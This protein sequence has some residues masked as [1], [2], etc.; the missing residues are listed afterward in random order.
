MTSLVRKCFSLFVLVLV[1]AC[2]N[3]V[4]PT[5]V[6]E[7]CRITAPTKPD[8]VSDDAL[9]A[10]ND[11]QLTLSLYLDRRVRQGYEAQLEAAI[12]QCQ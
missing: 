3:P 12:Q 9:K 1:A 4:R 8:M 6:I 7:K 2:S 10:M 11:Y 5:S